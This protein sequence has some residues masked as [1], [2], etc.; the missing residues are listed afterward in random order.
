V[1][2]IHGHFGVLKLTL[3]SGGYRRAFIDV[4]GRLWDP[5]AGKCH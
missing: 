4:S 5:G 2:Q 3:G 1:S